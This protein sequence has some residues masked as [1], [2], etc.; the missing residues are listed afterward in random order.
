MSAVT[1]PTSKA[2]AVTDP[3][4]ILLAVIAPSTIISDLTLIFGAMMSIPLGLVEM[5]E[6]S[7]SPV[8]VVEPITTPSGVTCTL[9]L[10]EALRTSCLISFAV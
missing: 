3:A 4:A 7:C 6:A 2:S 1:D 5:V 8:R 10:L 9:A